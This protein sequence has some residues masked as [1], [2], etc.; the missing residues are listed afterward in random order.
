MVIINQSL[1]KIYTMKN[2]FLTSFITIFALVALFSCK[3]TQE[4]DHL[5]VSPV[6]TLYSPANNHF[7]K[8]D[9][10]SGTQTFEWQQA[11]AED[12]GLV[13]YEVLFDKESGDFSQPLYSIPSDNNGTAT[14]LTLSD[15]QINKIAEKV[16]IKPTE[17]GKLKWTVWS[18]KGINVEKSAPSALLEVQR[19]LGFTEIPADLYITGSA[20][21]AG[22]DLS[23]AIRMKKLS[24]STYEIITS[25]KDGEYFFVDR[26]TG[27][28][29]KFSNNNGNIME[30]GTT[31]HAGTKVYQIIVDFEKVTVET[32]EIKRLE[33]YFAPD[34]KYIQ[35][36]Y[37]GNS[38]FKVTTTVTFKQESWGRDER[39]KFLMVFNNNGTDEFLRLA[40]ANRDNQRATATTPLSYYEFGSYDDSRWDYTFKFATEVDGKEVDI[41]ADFSPSLTKYTH[42]V[43]IK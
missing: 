27:T 15:A 25:L 34:D 10:K 7:I 14:T 37:I 6:A 11:R 24:S 5:K 36:P 22:T 42:R 31:S 41:I 13:M 32:K 43:V 18:S 39:Y 28:P 19:P 29:K 21:E 2:N 9:P 26:N 17:T 23:K 1:K 3:K 8:L 20:T 35:M 40:S 33:Y 30:D 38:Q 4:L 12:G 16:G